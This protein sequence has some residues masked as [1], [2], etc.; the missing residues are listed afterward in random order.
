[1]YIV[2]ERPTTFRFDSGEG[3]NG[4]VFKL[5][6]RKSILFLTIRLILMFVVVLRK[7]VEKYF[8]LLS[9]IAFR[10]LFSYHQEFV[11]EIIFFFIEDFIRG[12]WSKIG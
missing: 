3:S 9:Q 11:S 6:V 12:R 8:E 7:W 1:M 10:I 2:Y 4:A 5:W